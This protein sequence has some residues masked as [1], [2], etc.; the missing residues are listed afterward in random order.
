L[1]ERFLEMNRLVV[2]WP[3]L[4]LVGMVHTLTTVLVG[5]ALLRAPVASHS[6]LK[7]LILAVLGTLAPFG[8]VEI[9]LRMIPGIR[10]PLWAGPTLPHVLRLRPN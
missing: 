3:A 5:M 6:L 4:I 2:P 9:V 7:F 8:L 10:S 1:R